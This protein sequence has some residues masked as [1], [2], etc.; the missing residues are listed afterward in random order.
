MPDRGL[1]ADAVE[2]DHDADI[3]T[4]CRLVVR[5]FRLLRSAHGMALRKGFI[6]DSQP[7]PG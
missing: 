2:R 7:V 1:A 6:H 4:P 5:L 3:S